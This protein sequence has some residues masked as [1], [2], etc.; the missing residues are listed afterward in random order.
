MS[1]PI[2]ECFQSENVDS[3]SLRM[4][5]DVGGPVRDKGRDF[6]VISQH[7]QRNIGVI[8]TRGWRFVYYPET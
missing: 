2:L 6:N 7:E 8:E 4:A 5:I 3:S 1:S